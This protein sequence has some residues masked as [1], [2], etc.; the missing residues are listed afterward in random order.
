MAI[1]I[2][3]ILASDT[4]SELTDK[5]NFNFDQLLLNGGG[6][7]GPPGR[8]LRGFRGARGARG[9]IFY[10]DPSTSSPGTDPNNLIF[11]DLLEDD[12]YIQANG[13]VWDYN[14]TSWDLTNLNL[15]GPT[16]PAGTGSGWGTFGN[17]LNNQQSIYPDPFPVTGGADSGNES[18]P[19]VTVG[20]FPSNVNPTYTPLTDRSKLEDSLAKSLD[21]SNTSLFINQLDSSANA[22]VLHGG[23]NGT[24][25]NYSDVLSELVNFQLLPDDQLKIQIPKKPTTPALLTDI[26]GFRI[27]TDDSGQEFQ[28]GNHITFLTGQGTSNGIS[29]ENNFTVNAGKS[30]GSG[31]DPLISLNVLATSGAPDSSFILGGSGTVTSTTK[32]GSI[33]AEG[34][35]INIISSST[36][37]LR[38][39][40]I[41]QVISTNNEARIT[42]TNSN[43]RLTAGNQVVIDSASFITIQSAA[44]NI[45]MLTPADILIRAG[46]TSG[47]SPSGNGLNIAGDGE[48]IIESNTNLRFNSDLTPGTNQLYRTH[49]SQIIVGDVT[50]NVFQSGTY[51]FTTGLPSGIFAVRGV[52]QRI[53]RSV[54]GSC[55]VVGAVTPLKKIL[56]PIVSLSSSN[57]YGVASIETALSTYTAGFIENTFSSPIGFYILRS[58]GYST[59]ARNFV[60]FSY[61]I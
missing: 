35:L 39:L 13:D 22:I 58:N 20:G 36:A 46:G 33:S 47:S 49:T 14:G 53:G 60:N 6:P 51:S 4:I 32:T 7:P 59:S 11:A 19:V 38:A 43:V 17:P 24:S 57:I 10:E 15:E 8:G 40:N 55:E 25:E 9:T 37:T 12:K 3:E 45:D 44:D 42:S 23:D 48:I 26:L 21:A 31:S 41:A 61:Q 1:T 27:I 50:D 54:T 29:N 56:L 28:S 30:S 16:G 5:I 18:V 52:W 2:R 34:G